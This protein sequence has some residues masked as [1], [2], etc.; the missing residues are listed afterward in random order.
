MTKSFLLTI[1]VLILLHPSISLS[2]DEV[3]IYRWKTSE[4]YKW[5]KFGEEETHEKYEGEVNWSG[6]PDGLGTFTYLDGN[7]Y[8]GEFIEEE[9]SGLGT[10]IWSNHEDREKYVGEFTNDK[11]GKVGKIY[12]KNGQIYDGEVFEDLEY[13]KGIKTLP[14]GRRYEGTWRRTKGDNI[15]KWEITGYDKD[16]NKILEISE[17]EGEGSYVFTNGDEYEGEW[18]NGIREGNGSQSYSSGGR[19]EG[20]WK[21][22][23]WDGKG[24]FYEINGDKY[25]GQFRNWNRHG[26]GIYT[27]TNGQKYDGQWI[28]GK[29][30]G[31][32]IMMFKSGEK[33]EGEWKNDLFNGKGTYLWSDSRYKGNWKNGKIT[34]YGE[35]TWKDG[36][37]YI[38]EF[39]NG[40]ERGQGKITYPDGSIYVGSWNIGQYNGQ[41]TLTLPNGNKLVGTWKNDKIWN[42]KEKNHKGHILMKF[43]NGVSIR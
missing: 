21:K 23:L 28:D 5:K 13:G 2:S 12:Y 6:V 39:E 38:G 24:T 34:G 14:D 10:Y 8:K 17:G 3:T 9:R 27:W 30:H 15:T 26:H 25:V 16:E 22:D 41:G 1:S 37:K 18:K 43:V 31:Y 35:F 11:F 33:Y 29:R 19:Y 20:E 4:G 7:K 36:R 42:G 32:G 40:Y